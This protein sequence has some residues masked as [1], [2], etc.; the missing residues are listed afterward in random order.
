MKILIIEDESALLEVLRDKFVKSGFEVKTEKDGDI[1]IKS[2]REF[3]PDMIL[4]DLILPKRSGF[5]VLEELKNDP[6]TKPIPVIVLSNLDEDDDIKKAL[7]VGAVDYF[8]KTQHPIN[9]VVE[10]VKDYILSS[11]RHA[12]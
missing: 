12:Q 4:L 8:T 5:E 10:K 1:D 11:R 3:F 2:I 7:F 9:E 6:E